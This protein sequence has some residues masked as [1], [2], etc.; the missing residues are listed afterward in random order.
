M[1]AALGVAA[2]SLAGERDTELPLLG[3][4]ATR[5]ASEIASSSWSIGGE[6]LDRDFADHSSYKRYLG[7][8]GAKHIRLQ[9]GWARC[10]K[11]MGVYD[12]AWLDAIMGDA[13][14][15]G[16]K[17][18]LET[19]YGNTIYPGGG[20]TG[21]A[22]GLP[23]SDEALA[24]WDHWVR[25]LV[26]RYRTRVNE[27]EIW[28]EPDISKE[29]TPEQYAALFV[30]TATIIR[31]EQ[32]GARIFA[33]G[34]AGNIGFAEKFLEDVARRERLDLVDAITIHG[35]PRNPDDTSNLDRLRAVIARFG[36]QIEVRQGETGAPSQ[37]QERFALSKLP[38]TESTQAKWN[39]RRM[40]VHH[41]QGVPFNLFTIS[42]MHYAQDGALHMNYKGLLATN[43]DKTISRAKP[44]YFAAQCVF[45][46]FDDSLERVQGFTCKASVNDS[47]AAHAWRN[48]TAGAAVV[49][50]WLNGAPPVEPNT[51][52][53]ADVTFSGVKFAEPVLADLLTG[54]VRALPKS[55]DGAS[56][57]SVPLYDSPVLI[58]EK[59]ALVLR[60]E[61]K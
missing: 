1:F 12:W 44:A 15:Q 46:I 58:A 32:K 27:W 36:R 52:A 47:L 21:L 51:A 61:K 48:K 19:S 18:W 53:L 30:R 6:T 25:A 13:I 59:G 10:E 14:A 60:A 42:D 16:L 54:E 22:G 26:R 5:S 31:A 11:Q 29:N 49:A 4:L 2:A 55:G 9:A 3:H 40:L 8:L 28:N 50:L 38:W 39:L 57:K 41:A 35:Y 34:L 56:F 20:G 7:P 17:P 33:L 37:F 43:D 24:A 45:A 23:K